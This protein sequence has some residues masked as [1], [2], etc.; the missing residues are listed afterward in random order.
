MVPFESPTMEAENGVFISSCQ[1]IGDQ[2]NGG[3]GSVGGYGAGGAIKL[4]SVSGPDSTSTMTLD[5]DT[6]NNNS[7]TGGNGT[8]QGGDG[9]GGAVD[10][11]AD[12]Q[13][14]NNPASAP[15]Q[16]RSWTQ[17]RSPGSRPRTV[18][19]GTTVHKGAPGR[20]R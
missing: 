15:A 1:F 12:N 13:S 5:S 9:D 8:Q 2:A 17:L 6:F 3:S 18:R 20:R 4:G 14:P 11:M 7:A 19:A 10:L 16:P